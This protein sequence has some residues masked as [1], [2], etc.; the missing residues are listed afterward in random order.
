MVKL[1]WIALCFT[2]IPDLP[3]R[4]VLP[5]LCLCHHQMTHYS[6]MLVQSPSCVTLW[7]ISLGLRCALMSLLKQMML[8]T[9]C[10]KALPKITVKVLIQLRL[11]L[12]RSSRYMPLIMKSLHRLKQPH[13]VALRVAVADQVVAVLHRASHQD[14]RLVKLLPRSRR[15]LKVQLLHH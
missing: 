15:L 9:L 13:Q 6:N 5:A 1:L 7:L 11:V 3:R 10:M 12:P 8:L 2:P 4:C 14:L